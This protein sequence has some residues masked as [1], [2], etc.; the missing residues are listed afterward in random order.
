MTSPRATL[1]LLTNCDNRCVFCAPHGSAPI[2][3]RD[4]DAV[5]RDL[6]AL[7][8]HHSAITFTGGEPALHPAL[9]AIITAAR[10]R[11]FM[12]VGIQTNG[13]R[14]GESGYVA[15]LRDA[16]LSDAHFS[17]HGL[18][19]AI[20]DYHTGVPGSFVE[21]TAGLGA[22]RRAGLTT[23]V[24]TVLTRSNA[25]ALTTLAPWLAGK[26]VAAWTLT[27]P[28]TAGRLVAAF[29]RV[30]PRLV[31][32]MPYA[33]HA[34][35]LAQQR[36]VTVFL[37]GAPLCMLGPFA[38]R[39]LPDDVRAFDPTRCDGCPV[40]ARCPGIDARYLRRF[41]GDEFSMTRAP[42]SAPRPFTEREQTLAGMFVGEGALGPGDV[43]LESPQVVGA[44]VTL[45]IV[46][47]GA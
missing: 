39:S 4:I 3:P 29:D 24:T 34:L 15:S 19:P 8:A 37:R 5:T 47:E 18:G 20:H 7:A 21:A 44:R 6:D 30:F 25:R 10:R 9:P 17:L 2:A 22:A 45:P 38:A 14:L 42:I 33:L 27:I 36:G 40:R 43:E 26:G 41:G 11:G 1:A 35:D 23:T 31:M 16:G 13:R 28:R 32:A 46:R 12:R